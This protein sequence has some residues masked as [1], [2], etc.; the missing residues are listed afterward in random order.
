MTSLLPTSTL[1]PHQRFS[2]VLRQ[3][4]PI[5][6]FV[7]RRVTL[8]SLFSPRSFLILYSDLFKTSYF[9]PYNCYSLSTRWDPLHPYSRLRFRNFSTF[10]LILRSVYLDENVLKLEHLSPLEVFFTSKEMFYSLY[11]YQCPNPLSRPLSFSLF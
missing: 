10:S 11:F 5:H 8:D 4:L 3:V 2:F 6:L 9:E 7:E 1:Y